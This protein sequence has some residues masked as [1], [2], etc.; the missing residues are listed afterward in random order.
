MKDI[1]VKFDGGTE[2]QGEST[3]TK[4]VNEIE[5]SSFNHRIVQ[6]KSSSA[7]TAGGHGGERPGAGFDPAAHLVGLRVASFC[8]LYLKSISPWHI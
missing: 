6:P 4:H 5:V 2:L 1:Y 3:D 7:S 8:A